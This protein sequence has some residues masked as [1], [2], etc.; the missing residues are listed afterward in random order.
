MRLAYCA[1]IIKVLVQSKL[2]ASS[3]DFVEAA[4]KQNNGYLSINIPIFFFTAYPCHIFFPL[5]CHILQQA[6]LGMQS[7]TQLT[8]TIHTRAY[9]LDQGPQRPTT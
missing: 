3:S 5:F 6:E 2:V 9:N 4:E 8:S 1:T 7:V